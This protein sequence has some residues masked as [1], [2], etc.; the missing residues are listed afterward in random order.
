MNVLINAIIGANLPILGSPPVPDNDIGKFHARSPMELWKKVYE[1]LFPPKV[2]ISSSFKARFFT[3]IQQ[4][5]GNVP[6]GLL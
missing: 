3:T 6:M 4:L 5:L 2:S 1:K